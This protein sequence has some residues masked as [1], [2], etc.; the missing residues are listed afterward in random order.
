MK[1]KKEKI[2]IKEDVKFGDYIL[3]TTKSNIAFSGKVVHKGKCECL[4]DKD[5][6]KI[7]IK[8]SEKS[9]VWLVFDEKAIKDL[10]VI[11]PC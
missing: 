5:N 7:I 1:K 9:D 4:N 10:Q 3:I 11:V 2:K 8:P 6:N